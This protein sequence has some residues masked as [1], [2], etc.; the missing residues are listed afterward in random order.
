[1]HTHTLPYLPTYLPT[2]VSLPKRGEGVEGGKGIAISWSRVAKRRNEKSWRTC[3][4]VPLL[5]VRRRKA[6]ST[7]R[8]WRYFDVPEADLAVA[9]LDL[10]RD[11]RSILAVAQVKPSREGVQSM[12]YREA[13]EIRWALLKS[14]IIRVFAKGKYLKEPKIGY[15]YCTGC[16]ESNY[17]SIWNI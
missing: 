10:A 14:S 7:H 16:S 5:R 3:P 9:R 13:E 12:K 17:T 4:L 6:G 2:T 11:S 15:R 8:T 1:M